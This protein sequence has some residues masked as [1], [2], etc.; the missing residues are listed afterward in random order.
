M[1]DAKSVCHLLGRFFW[2]TPEKWRNVL[3]LRE[4]EA[5]IVRGRSLNR[6][7][8]RCNDKKDEVKS[9]VST[10]RIF[11]KKTPFRKEYKM[12]FDWMNDSLEFSVRSDKDNITHLDMEIYRGEN[13]GFITKVTFIQ[14]QVKDIDNIIDELTKL[15]PR[16][17]AMVASNNIACSERYKKMFDSPSAK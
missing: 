6:A 2:L 10:I 17:A 7:F 1:R 4:S 12:K 15:R 13:I 14:P 9:S 16:L 8:R 5:I 11:A 3:D